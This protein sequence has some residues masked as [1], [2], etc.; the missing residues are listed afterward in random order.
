M[1]AVFIKQLCN[2]NVSDIDIWLGRSVSKL[3][4]F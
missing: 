1:D 3:S 4:I 2:T